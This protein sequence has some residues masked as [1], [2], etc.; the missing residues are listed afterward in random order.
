MERLGDDREGDDG[1]MVA[2]VEVTIERGGV[3]RLRE[4]MEMK[5]G[6]VRWRRENRMMVVRWVG[7]WGIVRTE[8]DE[9]KMDDKVGESLCE[10]TMGTMMVLMALGLGAVEGEMEWPDATGA[11]AMKS[12]EG[13]LR[14]MMEMK[15]CAVR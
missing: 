7:L 2:V 12:G 14:E 1:E 9:R 6:A 10:M 13:R 11:V 5:M 3:D 8:R 15:M 4:M